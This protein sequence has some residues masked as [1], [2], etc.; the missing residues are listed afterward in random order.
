[1]FWNSLT[2]CL[3]KITSVPMMIRV[4]SARI[5]AYSTSPWPR[6][7]AWVRENTYDTRYES[8]RASIRMPPRGRDCRPRVPAPAGGY[9]VLPLGY[10]YM[11]YWHARGRDDDC[12]IGGV[13]CGEWV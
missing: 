8:G 11:H 9:P 1:M 3:P 2:I 6:V 10:V 4:T 13:V 5:S 7:R 12:V